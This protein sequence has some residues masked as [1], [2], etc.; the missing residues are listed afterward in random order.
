M[1]RS[2]KR[3]KGIATQTLLALTVLTAVKGV[4]NFMGHTEKYYNLPMKRAVKRAQNMGIPCEYWVR[5]DGVKMFGPWVICA[6]HPSK[7]R[8]SR[9]DTSLGEGI[10][11]DTHTVD[12]KELIDIATNW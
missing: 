4:N 5:E 6:A 9:I 8:Y 2:I 10:I 11:L 1:T 12:D 3:L 7:I